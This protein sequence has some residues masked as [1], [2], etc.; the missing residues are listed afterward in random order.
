MDMGVGFTEILLILLLVLIFFGSK[1]L[2]KFVRESA[3]LFAKFRSYSDNVRR[4]LN[5]L[6]LNTGVSGPA[7]E[8]DTVRIQKRELRNK[9]LALRRN[10]TA[11]ERSEKSRAICGHIMNTP[12]CQNANAIMVYVNIDSEVETRE[13]IAAM[14]AAGKRILVPYTRRESRSLGL[15]EIRDLEN[16]IVTGVNNVPEAKP[17]LRDRFFR[18]DLQLVLCPGVCFDVF[19]GRLGRGYAY[20]DNFLRELRGRVPMFGMAFDCQIHGE[21][22]PFSYSDIPMDQIITESGLKLPDRPA[23]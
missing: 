9:Y 1:E 7:H 11:A 8:D 5:E 19:G 2:P 23:G 16:D 6:S 3:R 13:F 10:L 15:G 17:E 4:E 18:S 21:H 14:I 12:C 20:Y 22:L